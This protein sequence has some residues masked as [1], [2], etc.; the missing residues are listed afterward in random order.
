MQGDLQKEEDKMRRPRKSTIEVGKSYEG[1]V[2]QKYPQIHESR[3]DLNY[4]RPDPLK[5]EGL[6]PQLK[7]KWI[8]DTKDSVALA[9]TKGYI[10]A[11][12]SHFAN[13]S[14]ASL[15]FGDLRLFVIPKEIVGERKKRLQM[16]RQER[17]TKKL[18][19]SVERDGINVTDRQPK[20]C[21]VGGWSFN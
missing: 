12:K 9:K 18:R 6:D 7:A 5:I 1:S 13:S 3:E 11:Q 4:D 8:R 14:E 15:S 19:A 20:K 21:V 17:L 16:E 10:P 2:E